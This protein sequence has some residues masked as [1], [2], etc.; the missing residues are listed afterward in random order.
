[1]KTLDDGNEECNSK[2]KYAYEVT[3]KR[4]TRTEDKDTAEMQ[5]FI[6][7][8]DFHFCIFT[9]CDCICISKRD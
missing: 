8:P 7:V 3:S 1:M 5:T 2:L 4:S 9:V 6:Y